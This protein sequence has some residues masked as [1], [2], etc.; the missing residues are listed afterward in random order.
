M[1]FLKT[2]PSSIKDIETKVPKDGLLLFL[3]FYQSQKL[4]IFFIE[5]LLK[6]FDWLNKQA[7]FPGAF[8]KRLIQSHKF[9]KLYLVDA[10]NRVVNEGRAENNQNGVYR[11]KVNGSLEFFNSLPESS[12]D[13]VFLD[14]SNDVPVLKNELLSAFRILKKNGVLAGSDYNPD[15]F[16]EVVQAVNEFAEECGLNPLLTTE[17]RSRG[18]VFFKGGAL[19]LYHL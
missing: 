3:P 17:K 10:D 12:L 6:N 14:S 1:H 19:D 5:D 18:F 7:S 15:L 8:T 4:N 13:F 16:P 9:S 11:V 2:L